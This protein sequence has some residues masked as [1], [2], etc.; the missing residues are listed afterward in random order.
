MDGY[1]TIRKIRQ[2]PAYADLPI[3]AVTA[4]ALSEDQEKCIQA[5]ASDYLPKPVDPDRLVEMI[6][7]WTRP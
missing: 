3:I 6:S 5:G 7:R 1:E 4:K 2:E